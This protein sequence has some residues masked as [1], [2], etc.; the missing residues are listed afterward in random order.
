MATTTGGYTLV[1]EKGDYTYTGQTATLL[2]SKVVNALNGTYSVTGQNA[3][4]SYS[5]SNTITLKA[6]SW[7]RYRIIQ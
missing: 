2:R 4:L 7:L 6:G 1:A 5:G 3:T